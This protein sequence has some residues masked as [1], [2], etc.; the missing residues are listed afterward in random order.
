MHLF[1]KNVDC[2]CVTMA[3]NVSRAVTARAPCRGC[4]DRLVAAERFTGSSC[5]QKIID[6]AL[7]ELS[8]DVKFNDYR[9]EF[10][11]KLN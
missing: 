11:I 7:N 6:G 10:V 5:S 4:R 3:R 9:I 8:I 2:G 1:K